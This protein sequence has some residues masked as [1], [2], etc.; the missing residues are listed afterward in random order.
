MS[1][2]NIVRSPK[3]ISNDTICG[4]GTY[5]EELESLGITLYPNPSNGIFKL[6]G[7]NLP[8]S[9]IKIMDLSGR[10]LLEQKIS[11]SVE[12]INFDSGKGLYLIVID[13]GERKVKAKLVIQ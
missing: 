11:N 4:N 6:E 8:G 10:V 3:R 7:D 13:T 9:V 5:V 2:R 12:T 1:P